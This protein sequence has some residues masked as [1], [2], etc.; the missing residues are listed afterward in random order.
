MGGVGWYTSESHT[1]TPTIPRHNGLLRESQQQASK[2]VPQSRRASARA[3]VG[4]SAPP[5][6]DA[7]LRADH[8]QVPHHSE[9]RSTRKYVRPRR[10]ANSL[11]P[12][13]PRPQSVLAY[14]KTLSANVGGDAGTPARRH[15]PAHAQ[16]GPPRQRP[17]GD[18]AEAGGSRRRLCRPSG[19]LRWQA[20]PGPPSS[21]KRSGS[22]PR[23]PSA[24][25]RV[26]SGRRTVEVTTERRTH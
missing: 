23:S 21:P 24:Q 10:S 22:T 18:P 6:H 9:S 15:R 7:P 25:L 11:E 5:P 2:L 16:A 20:R 12:V 13:S 8:L 3:S 19:A 1:H 4:P 14:S 26:K 17:G